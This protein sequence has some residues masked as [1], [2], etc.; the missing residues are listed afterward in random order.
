MEN[1]KLVIAS[2]GSGKTTFLVNEALKV[3]SEKIVLITTYTEVNEAEIINRI[4]E[5][6]GYIPSNI[7]VQTW[8]SF[9]IQHG[10]KPY[11]SVLNEDIHESNIAFY[12]T[13]QKSGFRYRVGNQ[14]RY[15][16][17]KDFRKYYF[18]DSMKIY[19]DKVSKF[20][21]KCNKKSDGLVID[22]ISRI[23]D[24]ILV[25]EVQDLAGYDLELIKILFKSSSRILL[26]GDP[27]QVTYLTHHEAKYRKYK[28]GKIKDFV[29]HKL[30]KRIV[31]DVDEDTL[32]TSHRNNQSICYYSGKLYPD[33]SA[34]KAC[35]C[36][37]CRRNELIHKGVFLVRES[38]VE[39]YC[40][41]YNPCQL[42]WSVIKKVSNGYPV[43]NFGESKGLSFDRVLIYPTE[44][45]LNWIKNNNSELPNEARA[46][47]YVG[48]T[49]ARFSVAIVVDSDTYSDYDGIGKYSIGKE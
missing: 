44:K 47:F 32:N 28:D 45:M 43:K 26:V 8:F 1:N 21:I 4:V 24:H 33:L 5:I 2:A 46:K 49:R 37:N 35:S 18:T 6:K 27:R 38:D 13:N 11:Q 41:K 30:G 16:G 39:N 31:C 42:R 3:P 17:E 36:T 10:V 34:S 25:D 14:N 20:I 23:Y 22:R 12:L 7:T 15:W 40:K 29:I 48:I 9:L 19:S